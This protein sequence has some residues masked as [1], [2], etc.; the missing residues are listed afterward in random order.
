MNL[1]GNRTF[2]TSA[3]LKAVTFALLIV[4]AQ[5]CSQTQGGASGT[6]GLAVTSSQAAA[7]GQIP[8]SAP[9][10]ASVTVVHGRIVSVDPENKVV[11]LQASAGKQLLLH[12]FNQDSLAAAKAG[13]PFIARFYEMASV[14]KLVPGQYPTAESLTA[15]IVNAVPD[16]TPGAPFGSQ[17]QFE[18]TIDAIDKNNKTVSIKGMD[19][20][21]EV[22]VVTNTQSLD[23]VQVGEQIVVTL[24]DVVAITLD[25]EGGS[26]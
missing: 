1:V 26:A 14:Q 9:G 18:V 4:I 23:Q 5:A 25:K 10:A 2:W 6:N 20:V 21:V 22:V 3:F 13:E 24:I 12:V 16:Q 19:G 17:Y 15:G 7:G 8:L 11:T